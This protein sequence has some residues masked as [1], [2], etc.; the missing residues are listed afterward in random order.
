MVNCCFCVTQ[1]PLFTF[2]DEIQTFFCRKT[3]LKCIINWTVTSGKLFQMKHCPIVLAPIHLLI[4]SFNWNEFEKCFS[5]QDQSGW[6]NQTQISFYEKRKIISHLFELNST[7]YVSINISKLRK[8]FFVCVCVH[9]G[10]QKNPF[11]C[12]HFVLCCHKHKNSFYKLNF[13]CIH[14][15]DMKKNILENRNFYC[16][17]ELFHLPLFPTFWFINFSHFSFPG[18]CDCWWINK[19]YAWSHDRKSTP[20]VRKSEWT[21]NQK[22]TKRKRERERGGV[23]KTS[24]P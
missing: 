23:R 15:N 3:Y 17:E 10:K 24:C 7:I 21:T 18:M 11:Q 14:V 4:I 9:D 8:F 16:L 13:T 1:W 5:L 20:I 2:L 6:V 19:S 22:S 12:F